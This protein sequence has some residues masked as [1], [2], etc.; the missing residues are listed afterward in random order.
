ML[1]DEHTIINNLPV[2]ST[3]S[4]MYDYCK[5]DANLH[6]I[7]VDIAKNEYFWKL[8]ELINYSKPKRYNIIN[9]MVSISSE[10]ETL[11]ELYAKLKSMSPLS[12]IGKIQQRSNAIRNLLG[13]LYPS[14]NW[15]ARDNIV[16]ATDYPFHVSTIMKESYIADSYFV[17]EEDM[18][19]ITKSD[20][21]YFNVTE[22]FYS[23][24]ALRGDH[25]VTGAY[26]RGKTK[27]LFLGLLLLIEEGRN[28]SLTDK[29]LLV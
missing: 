23:A 18:L 3:Y 24:N 14:V 28:I 15:S 4:E 25:K 21:I 20:L 17:P 29:Q 10:V 27:S 2:A 8:V 19:F 26:C 7:F 1:M 13:S 16:Y 9:Y 11:E 12:D 22:Y 5:K 6:P